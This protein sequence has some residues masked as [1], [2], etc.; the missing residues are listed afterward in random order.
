[1]KKICMKLLTLAHDRRPITSDLPYCNNLCGLS[2]LVLVFGIVEELALLV[3][4]FQIILP[5]LV[6]R[7]LGLQ[8][9]QI[10]VLPVWY[11][12]IVRG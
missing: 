10:M 3:I 1:M 6:L 2:K 8:L 12:K 11:H 5:Y 9:R 7:G 4:A